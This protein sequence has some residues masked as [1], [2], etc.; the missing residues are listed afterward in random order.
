MLERLTF[1]IDKVAGSIRR[2]QDLETLF[3]LHE[4]VRNAVDVLYCDLISFCIHVIRFYVKTFRY[5]F[6]SFDKKFELAFEIIDLHDAKIDRVAN[7]THMKKSK[8]TREYLSV[9]NK[10]TDDR[11]EVKSCLY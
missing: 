11:T 10:D 1:I 2:Y 5:S 8:E 4:D 7:A 3:A 9:E 6:V